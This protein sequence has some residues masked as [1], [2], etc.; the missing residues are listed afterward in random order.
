MRALVAEMDGEI[1]GVIGIVRDR[2]WGRFFSEFTPKLKPYL[3]SLKIMRAIKSALTFC[4][5]YQGPVMAVA[6]DAESCRIMNRLGF[7]HLYG[8]WYG[9]LR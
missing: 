5:E 4:D 2:E 9:W 1:V 8:A 7:T 3:K 6:E